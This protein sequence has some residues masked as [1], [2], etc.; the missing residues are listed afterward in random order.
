MSCPANEYLAPGN[1]YA[2]L[3]LRIRALSPLELM[4]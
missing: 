3:I 1:I 4:L 2:M